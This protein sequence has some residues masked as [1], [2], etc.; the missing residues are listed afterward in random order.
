ME[1]L[2]DLPKIYLQISIVTL[3]FTLYLIGLAVYRLFLSPI[4][5]IPGSKLTAVT[6]WYE[7]YYDVYK[8]GKFIFEIEKWH[9]Q[10]GPIVRINPW[11]VHFADP[12]FYD[13]LYSSKSRYSKIDH[14]RFRFGTPTASFD[15]TEHAL[16]AKRRGAM[17]PF[18]SRQ[19]ILNYSSY[20]AGRVERL[21][22]RLESEYKGTSKVFCF[23]DAWAS[24]TTDVINYYSF[25]M[26][27]D[28]QDY[29]DF[30]APFTK[31]IKLLAQ[32][33]HLVGHFPWVLS[34]LQSLPD[35]VVGVLN[36]A[37][38]P[39]FQF[40]NEI[41]AQIKRIV[42]EEATDSGS[43]TTDHKTVFS[44]MLKSDLPRAELSLDRLKHEA[45]S[46]T[47][48]GVDTIKNALVTASYGIIS[49]PAIYKRLHAELVEAMPDINGKPPT[50]PELE[51]LPYLNAIVQECLRLS[52]GITQ[53]LMRIDPHNPITFQTHTLPPNTPFSMT[54]YIQHRNPL[55]FPDPDTF[56]PDRWLPSPSSSS[57][58]PQTITSTLSSTLEKSYATAINPTNLN[59]QSNPNTVLAPATGRP[60]TKYL[61][62]F[63]RGPRACL[64]QNF[65]MAELFLDLGM[66]FRR[67]EFELVETGEREVKMVANYFAPFPES[68]K[69]VRVRVLGD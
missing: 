59:P 47:G 63:G 34:L 41:T 55:I 16:H 45:L 31:S 25:A 17:N 50:V 29:P 2:R 51:R 28:F 22:K 1:V 37:M 65:A 68:G 20:A 27:Y 24:L 35:S 42:H 18:F 12:D 9:Q 4:K 3:G 32:S 14:L 56:N 67:F 66:V 61:V 69:G 21:C 62:P 53:R 15:T 23:N 19:R 11:E 30:V 36:P 49:N 58:P 7:T 13:V 6:G 46:I 33:L 40:Q 52:Y 48:G 44:E 10:Y 38:V 54:S 39:V 8:G 60:L 26:S 57:S 64:G 5:N 43:K